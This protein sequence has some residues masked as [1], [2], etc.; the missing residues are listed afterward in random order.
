MNGQIAYLS[1]WILLNFNPCFYPLTFISGRANHGLTLRH[2][3]QPPCCQRLA[4]PPPTIQAPSEHV[5]TQHQQLQLRRP[6]LHLHNQLHSSAAGG[7]LHHCQH[8]NHQQQHQQ[9]LLQPKQPESFSSCAHSGQSVPFAVQPAK[10]LQLQLLQ[11]R[12][13]SHASVWVSCRL[14]PHTSSRPQLQQLLWQLH[15]SAGKKR[16][17]YSHQQSLPDNSS[18]N[19]ATGNISILSEHIAIDFDF[20]FLRLESE[21]PWSQWPNRSQSTTSTVHAWLQCLTK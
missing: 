16:Q 14:S 7:S 3:H 5:S 9:Q 21:L 11:S 1:F 19:S 4:P 13:Q 2:W 10:W 8:H 12:W 17:L 20:L 6:G 15:K 18:H